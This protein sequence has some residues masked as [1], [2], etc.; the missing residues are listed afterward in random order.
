[1]HPQLLDA[2]LHPLHECCG[3]PIRICMIK[4]GI[5][6]LIRTIGV[7]NTKWWCSR[8]R[9][10]RIKWPFIRLHPSVCHFGRCCLRPPSVLHLSLAIFTFSA[11]NWPGCSLSCTI[12]S[13]LHLRIGQK[14]DRSRAAS[15]EYRKYYR[16]YHKRSYMYSLECCL[17][18][19]VR[20]RGCTSILGSLFVMHEFFVAS[21]SNSLAVC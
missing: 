21:C 19:C 13:R 20:W 10:Y 18:V 15:P 16:I 17:E 4:Y 11:W 9:G 8:I 6:Q 5:H 12:P 7:Y 3:N 1:M 14:R 2:I